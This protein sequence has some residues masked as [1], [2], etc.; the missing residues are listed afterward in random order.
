MA[1]NKYTQA[2]V[3]MLTDAQ[4][5]KLAGFLQGWTIGGDCEA[6][7]YWIDAEGEHTGLYVWWRMGRSY[8]PSHDRNRSGE[9][10]QFAAHKMGMDYTFVSDLHTYVQIEQRESPGAWRK[11]VAVKGATARAETIAAVCALLA[12]EGRLL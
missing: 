5:D 3:E 2:D 11:I 1:L 8:S 9:L 4:L 7:N 10:L 12:I 6:N